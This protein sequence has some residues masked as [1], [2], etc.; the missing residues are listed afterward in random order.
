MQYD[1]LGEPVKPDS[2]PSEGKSPSGKG[3]TMSDKNRSQQAAIPA[4][5]DS[6]A[7]PRP[8]SWFREG[9]VTTLLHDS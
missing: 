1:L 9:A 2:R 4:N 7:R 8:F 3:V 5:G 6:F